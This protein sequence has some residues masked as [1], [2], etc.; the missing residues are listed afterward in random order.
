MARSRRSRSPTSSP[1]TSCMLNAGD[2][3]PADARL[4][5]E[6]DLQVRESALTGESLPVE[7]EAGDLGG[8]AVSM[9]AARNSLLPGHH[10]PD[11]HRHGGGGAHRARPPRSAP[12]PRTS[13]APSRDRVR[14]R[15]PPLRLAASS[16]VI[17]LLVIF[18]FAVNVWFH[19]QLLESLL[20]AVA[21]AVGLTPELL[22]VVISAT[23]A[24]GA[25][26]MARKKVIVK[27]LASIENFGS[28]E[29][30]C[31][32]K[33]GTLTEGEIV[34]DRHLDA[35]GHD[36]DRVMQL[37]YLNSFFQ[38]GIKSPLDDAVPRALS[39]PTIDRVSEARRDPLRLQPAPPLRRG[40]RG[41]ISACSSP[42]A[43]RRTCSQ[44]VHAVRSGR[45]RA[46]LRC[47]AAPGRRE[48]VYQE[49]GGEGYRVLGVATRA[50]DDAS[51][52][53]QGRRAGHD[54]RRVRRLPRPAERGRRG[55]PQGAARRRHLRGG[56]DR[57]QRVR[58]AQG[59]RATSASRPSAS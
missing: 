24:Q 3:V 54:A 23:L 42:R 11:R 19:P 41:A 39:T 48:A 25:R 14:S 1:A 46:A 5:E 56:D 51:R 37:L 28:I 30:L 9:A 53:H 6:K 33:T 15:H 57:R 2:L 8:E 7:K 18:V 44:C 20:F 34:L 49:L 38:A 16:R 17:V 36:D 58:D 40:G 26:A 50:V 52:L 43:R 13:P 45:G 29:I 22:P 59:R 27:Q 35:Q 31:S 32:D 21:L 55:D 4:L 47:S 12:S 10:R